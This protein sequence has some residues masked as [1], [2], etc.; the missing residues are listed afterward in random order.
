MTNKRF[1]RLFLKGYKK[2]KSFDYD[3]NMII[4]LYNLFV[5]NYKTTGY[6]FDGSN[7]SYLTNNYIKAN[8]Y[9]ELPKNLNSA[10]IYLEE[11]SNIIYIFDKLL[12]FNYDMLAMD[13][14]YN[15]DKLSGKV[16]TKKF[17]NDIF[18]LTS[19]CIKNIYIIKRSY[20]IKYIA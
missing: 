2:S 5:E 1:N 19:R 8:N 18:L 9:T 3:K 13:V 20:D 17:I 16:N 7:I 12:E 11:I 15:V 6:I 4:E 10:C 14:I